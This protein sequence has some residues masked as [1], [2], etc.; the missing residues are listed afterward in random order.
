M[1][2]ALSR[3]AVILALSPIVLAMPAIAQAPPELSN[4]QLEIA[5]VAPRNSA[6]EPVR[7]RLQKRH[8][9]EQLKQFLAPL[10]LPRKLTVQFDQCGGPARAYKSPGPASICY[11]LID[12]IEKI[13]VKAQPDM[14]ETVLVGTVVQVVLHELAHGVFDAFKV[15]LWG[16]EEDAADMLAAFIVLQFGEDVAR[17]VVIG[18]AV[19][20]ELSGQ[21][22]NGSAFASQG[23]PEAQRYFNYLCIA[24]GGAPKSFEFLVKA[25]EGKK[26]ILPEQRAQRC[27]REYH[28]F[29]KAFD[30]RIMPY[31]DPDLLVA[32]RS[33]PWLVVE[34]AK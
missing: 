11:E 4:P 19:F 30:L 26:P 29:R 15:P 31:V 28:Q 27:N 16:R 17:R 12:Q 14:R 1:K 20:W 6:L 18:T 21:A 13:A 7:E 23:S 9:L 10:T 22:W 24:Y 25:E 2:R 33:R 34:G 8:V 3:A 5:Y 32:I